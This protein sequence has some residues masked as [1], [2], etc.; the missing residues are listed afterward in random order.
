MANFQ[1][2]VNLGRFKDSIGCVTPVLAQ[3][4]IIHQ[5]ESTSKPKCVALANH[6]MELILRVFRT[7]PQMLAEGFQLPSIFHST[8]FASPAKQSVWNE[9]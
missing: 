6:S 8:H 4:E 3:A 5:S 2:P 9:I 1:G 7:W